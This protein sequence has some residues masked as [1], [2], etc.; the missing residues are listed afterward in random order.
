MGRK[1]WKKLIAAFRDGKFKSCRYIVMKQM[2]MIF[3]FIY[4]LIFSVICIITSE[5]L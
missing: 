5:F 4:F 1:Y 2:K 3:M